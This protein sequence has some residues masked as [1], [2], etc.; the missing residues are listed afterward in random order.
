MQKI[1]PVCYIISVIA[2]AFPFHPQAGFFF[3]FVCTS[4][5][6]NQR[7]STNA[8]RHKCICSHTCLSHESFTV[9]DEKQAD[10]SSVQELT[11]PQG[12]VVLK[13]F[14]VEFL[15]AFKIDLTLLPL[16]SMG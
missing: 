3:Y 8:G 5:S 12:Y 7:K 1:Y 14:R 4:H 15:K 9:W 10:T 11:A 2:L 13:R 16:T 6:D